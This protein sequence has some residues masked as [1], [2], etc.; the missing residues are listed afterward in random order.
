ME[1]TCF[2]L[3]LI[4]IWK[5]INNEKRRVPKYLLANLLALLKVLKISVEQG[6]MVT[7]LN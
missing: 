7:T 6:T 3:V 1:V 5:K 2:N 4:R